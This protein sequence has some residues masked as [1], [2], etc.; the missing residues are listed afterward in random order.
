M[1][2]MWDTIV[3]EVLGEDGQVT[4]VRTSNVQTGE[5]QVI[6][7]DGVFI[8]VGHTPNTAYLEG[9]VDLRPSGYVDVRDE[10]YTNVE[11]LFAAGDVADEIYRQLGTSIGA[12]TRA[13]MAA[14]RWLAEKE[15]SSNLVSSS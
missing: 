4:A 14:E 3:E 7:T 10:I 12:G 1:N 2:F 5:Q 11:G 15:T 13:A 8:Y 9:L 6:E